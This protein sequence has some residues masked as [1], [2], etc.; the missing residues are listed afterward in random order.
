MRHA[1]VVI[2][3]LAMS[4]C[5]LVASTDPYRTPGP[6][7]P[8][9]EISPANPRTLDDLV[10]HVTADS[11][12]P[13][14]E[15]VT[16]EYAW[17]KSGSTE[18]LG[19]AAV[20]PHAAT[21]RD[22]VWT[23]TVTPV[24]DG[25]RGDAAEGTVTIENTPPSLAYAGLSRYDLVRDE[26]VEVFLGPTIDPDGDSIEHRI[27]WRVNDATTS[28][29]SATLSLP[30][31]SIAGGERITVTV[32]PYDGSEEGDAV[33]VGPA[34]VRPRGTHFR[35]V[36]PQRNPA[37][38][39][40][41]GAITEGA[42][43]YDPRHR[44]W[45]VFGPTPSIANEVVAP[46]PVWE[47]AIDN[48]RWSLLSPG[49]PEG[50]GFLMYQTTPLMDVENG[51]V[52]FY[53]VPSTTDVSVLRPEVRVLDVRERGN[54]SW[55]VL[56]LSPDSDAPPARTFARPLFD[57][58][59]DRMLVYGSIV[60]GMAP[61]IVGG[62][63]SLRLGDSSASWESIPSASVGGFAGGTWIMDA[64]RDLAYLAG[65]TD[66]F[67]GGTPRTE[68]WRLDLTTDAFTPT[69][70]AIL[71]QG[72]VSAT[73][74]TIPGEREAF[75]FFGAESV[76]TSSILNVVRRFD[77]DSL[78]IETVT[79]TGDTAAITPTSA[80][81]MG[82]DPYSRRLQHAPGR[83]LRY[84]PISF[85]SISL[86]GT[87][88]AL[89]T[90][91]V[92][93]PTALSS[94]GMSRSSVRA[95]ATIYFGLRTPDEVGITD[96]RASNG[97]FSFDRNGRFSRAE[98]AGA[99]SDGRFGF[100]HYADD[101]GYTELFLGGT[102]FSSGSAVPVTGVYMLERIQSTPFSALGATAANL[103]LSNAAVGHCFSDHYYVAG[104][105]SPDHAGE[106]IFRFEED[107]C[108]GGTCTPFVVPSNFG[109]WHEGAAT[110]RLGEVLW[111][112]GGSSHGQ[113][114]HYGDP[115]APGVDDGDGNFI[116]P[117]Q[118]A[119]VL[120]LPAVLRYVKAFPIDATH[121]LLIGSWSDPGSQRTFDV[122][123]IDVTTPSAPTFTP[124][125]PADGVSPGVR[126]DFAADDDG[127]GNVLVYGG[128]DGTN[129]GEPHTYSDLWEL[130][131]DPLP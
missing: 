12:D 20:L 3:T 28:I 69:P 58:E 42:R 76:V 57:A 60:I 73:A 43:V 22:E 109:S 51:R 130:R 47:Y 105:S 75:I 35:P 90:Y 49:N 119:Q 111:V 48:G 53:E 102:R 1:L 56:P 11:L 14:G 38:L 21:A 120:T 113:A 68:V 8:A 15:A 31:V 5:S 55:Q 36:V 64:E 9:I 95:D 30:S 80:P 103:N 59:R 77:L 52:I 18:V 91:G 50:G 44:R 54:E 71:P 82:F 123:V 100:A 97:I 118:T 27:S 115:C 63:W 106:P 126:Y 124:V 116:Q 10:V 17:R 24:A 96:A 93:S 13:R 74:I 67:L 16:Y 39:Q 88:A 32:T 114:V 79:L 104:A 40:S 92:T 108:T 7:A 62:L 61:S 128:T 6:S 34:R 101:T 81:A 19:D 131:Y 83:V 117:W 125:L 107:N 121:F 86:D 98:I 89:E 25:R 65:G 33:T 122:A 112:L 66:N 110:V 87:V 129:I 78:A 99:P 26:S 37:P 127:R 70:V 85:A 46:G 72:F 94:A 23:V 45:L 4:G 84:L 41:F 29:T 2:A